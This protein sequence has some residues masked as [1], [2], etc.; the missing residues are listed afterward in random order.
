MITLYAVISMVIGCRKYGIVLLDDMDFLNHVQKRVN[1]ETIL[2]GFDVVNYYNYT[3][4]NLGRE[5][6]EFL[7][8]KHQQGIQ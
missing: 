8:H 3:P 6:V 4:H 5:A 7:I 2:I 1:K